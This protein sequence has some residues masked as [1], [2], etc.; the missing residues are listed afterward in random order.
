MVQ[1]KILMDRMVGTVLQLLKFFAAQEELWGRPVAGPWPAAASQAV[2]RRYFGCGY[3]ALWGRAILPTACDQ[4]IRL[5]GTLRM[6]RNLSA[7]TR[8][9]SDK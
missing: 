3:A 6:V 5:I 7:A 1:S 8:R 9:G 4:V 2:L